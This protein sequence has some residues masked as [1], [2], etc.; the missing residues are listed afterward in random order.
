MRAERVPIAWHS[1]LPLYASE[2]F[3]K[4]VGDDY[5]WLG[6]IDRAGAL[7]CVLPYTLLRKAFFR[8][9]RFRVETIPLQGELSLLEEKE[10]L[11]SAME[12]FR[13]LNADIVIPATTNTVFRTYPD[14]A[15]VAPYGSYVV[16]LTQPEDV[17]W[18]NLHSKHRNVIRNAARNG[19]VVRSGLEYLS[20]AYG[21][22]KETVGRSG[23]GFIGYDALRQLVTSLGDSVRISI[24]EYQGKMHGAA[25]MPF[26][27]YAAY[28]LYGGSCARPFSGATNLLQ[29]ESMLHFK[30]LGVKRYDF[31][32]VRI[33]P[34]A[35]SKQAGLMVFKERFGGHL[36]RGFMW[37][38]PLNRLGAATYS[39]AVKCMR[40]GDIVDQERRRHGDGK[41]ASQ[42]GLGHIGRMPC[43]DP[44]GTADPQ[45][46]DAAAR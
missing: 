40:G 46:S 30:S 15:I 9:V 27:D 26:S 14:G 29:W 45:P 24:A 25:V 33:N 32:G 18:R 17:L 2:C 38:L 43:V 11:N 20:A 31:V 3:L 16:D 22:I 36:K 7:R 5:G 44:A 39:A 42:A 8:L 23:L 34:D 6:G 12:Y 28:Y 21:L 35:G 19:V 1:G 10:F 37:K 41:A 4:V 13:S